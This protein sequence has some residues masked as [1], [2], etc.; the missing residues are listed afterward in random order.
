MIC[1]GYSSSVVTYV[2][3]PQCIPQCSVVPQCIQLNGRGDDDI[4]IL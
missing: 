3:V 2:L 1:I 4:Q